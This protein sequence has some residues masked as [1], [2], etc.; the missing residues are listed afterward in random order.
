MAGS[1]EIVGYIDHEQGQI[2]RIGDPCG[3]DVHEVFQAPVLF[4]I[5]KVKL[6]LEPQA[7]IVHEVGI[8]EVRVTT[9]QDDMSPRLGAKIGLGDDDDIQRLRVLLVEYAHLVQAG[10]DVPLNG[11]LFE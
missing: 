11:G 8:G 10:L 2:R 1:P 5:P 7:I 4:G 6:N 3:G 9:E